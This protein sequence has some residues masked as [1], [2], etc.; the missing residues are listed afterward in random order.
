MK[1]CGASV[2]KY[3]LRG[4]KAVSSSW[5]GGKEERDAVTGRDRKGG[6]IKKKVEGKISSQP[7]G[8]GRDMQGKEERGKPETT[9]VKAEEGKT[10]VQCAHSR[11]EENRGSCKESSKFPRL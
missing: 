9:A 7:T 10:S 1:F 6:L 4:K 11:P 8:R 3:G 2:P 5:G